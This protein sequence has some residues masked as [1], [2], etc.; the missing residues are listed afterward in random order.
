MSTE[1]FFESNA[2]KRF[3]TTNWFKL[4][5]RGERERERER[6]GG[7]DIIKVDCANAVK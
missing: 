6:G 3:C 1:P 7:G 2:G 4:R 5:E